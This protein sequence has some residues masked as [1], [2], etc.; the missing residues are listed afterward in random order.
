M[1][2]GAGI[3]EVEVLQWHVSVGDVVDDFDPLC[4]VQSDKATVE[5]TSRYAGTIKKVGASLSLALSLPP[6]LPPSLSDS[7]FSSRPALLRDG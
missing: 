1:L 6:V 3:A 2:G 5:I 4:E 7:V